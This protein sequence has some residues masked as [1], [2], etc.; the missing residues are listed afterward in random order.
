MIRITKITGED[1]QY[2]YTTEILQ[3]C[4]RQQLRT[5]DKEHSGTSR[6]PM[7]EPFTEAL[8]IEDGL[9]LTKKYKSKKSLQVWEKN[10]EV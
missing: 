2:T 5:S 1:C 6:D 7:Y 3:S 8:S 4:S 9:S 10:S